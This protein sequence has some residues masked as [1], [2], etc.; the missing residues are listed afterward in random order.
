M[1]ATV[2]GAAGGRAVP[3]YDLPRSAAGP[4]SPWLI[5]VIISIATFME[6]LDTTI[7]NVS[8]RH[9]AGSLAASQDE[10]TWILTS[11]LV[12]NAVVLPVSGWLANVIGR[13][14]FYMICVALFTISSALCSLATSLGFM[15]AMR[16]LQG[17]GGGG[18]A[19]SEQSMLADSFPPEKRAQVFALYGFTVVVAPA[20]GPVLGGWITDSFS[21]EWVFLI[22]I[23]VGI[24]SLTLTWMFVHE[25]PALKEDRRRLLSSGFSVDYV[26]F[27]LVALGFGA[28]QVV[29]DRFQQDDGFG[30]GF[31]VAMT[32][33]S[34]LSLSFLVLWE[35][36]HPHP[37]MNVRL[38]RI[39]PFAIANVV[40]FIIGFTLYSTTQLLPQLTQSLLGYDATTAGLTLG[41]GGLTT[42]LVMPLSGFVT[43]RY[44]QPKW[45]VAGALILTG[46]ALL[47]MASLS[48]EMDFWTVARARVLQA[49]ALPFLFIPLSAAM[50]VG[51]PPTA[52][53]EA[54]ALINLMRNLGGSV[55]VSFASTMLEWRTQ[56]HHARLAEHIT[57][58]TDLGG[59]S[60]GQIAQ[61]L[62]TQ[63]AFL[64][65]LDVFHLLGITALLVWPVV[66]FLR[67][68]PKG[69]VPAGH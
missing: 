23:P 9:I 38:L 8:L 44:I 60:L 34:G 56:F 26:G 3:Q 6:V 24:V 14:R 39:A 12:S 66:L 40:M 17:V 4:H 42:V 51:L 59:R 11:Y 48:P 10:S 13:K 21:W 29:L 41:L 49:L 22:N 36:Y 30:S 68:V 57:A 53:N 61:V 31:V 19:P 25:P 65:Y 28:L 32:V 67:P 64:S 45:L 55:G 63:A 18:L 27:A 52:S 54:S 7:A 69:A 62:Q 1:S 35:W 47:H 46:L 50:Y 15:I 58:S 2:A 20:I 33:V 16:V 37:A 5:A 43:V